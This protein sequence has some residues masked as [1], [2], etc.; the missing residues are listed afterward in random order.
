MSTG[1]YTPVEKPAFTLVEKS[2]ELAIWN[3]KEMCPV[4]GGSR[5]SFGLAGVHLDGTTR[6]RYR[7]VEHDPDH[8]Y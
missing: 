6:Q 7:C 8:V 1:I 3:G 5:G 2:H 4:C